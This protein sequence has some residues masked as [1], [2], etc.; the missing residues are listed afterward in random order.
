MVPDLFQRVHAAGLRVALTLSAK[1]D[2]LHK[3]LEIACIARLADEAISSEDIEESK[4]GARSVQGRLAKLTIEGKDAVAIGDTPYDAEAARKA[5][6]APSACSVQAS[7]RASSVMQD[8]SEVY[9]GPAA[10]LVC[11]GESLL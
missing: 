9:P 10:L 4:P 3:Y 1:K 11:F 7:P 5:S 6:P 8:V 2:E